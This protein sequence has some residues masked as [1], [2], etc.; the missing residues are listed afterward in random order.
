MVRSPENLHPGA[1]VDEVIANADAALAVLFQQANLLARAES[2]L[3]GHCGP[4][5]AAQFQVAA[6]RQDRLV[7][8]SP[9]AAWA[10]RLRMQAG[11]MLLFLQAVGY[12]HLRHLDI[13]D[14]QIA[15]QA[16]RQKVANSC[17]RGDPAEQMAPPAA[18]RPVNRTAPG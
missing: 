5:L 1:H 13:R 8:L 9:T 18:R 10:T 15:G 3:A 7:L 16:P 4:E 6:M 2:L 14:A 17:R 12:P 11:H